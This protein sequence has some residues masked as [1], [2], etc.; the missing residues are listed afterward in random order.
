M[1]KQIWDTFGTLASLPLTPA[2]FLHNCFEVPRSHAAS[3]VIKFD[4]SEQNFLNARYVKD[5]EI[6]CPW[7]DQYSNGFVPIMK[8]D[9]KRCK[10]GLLHGKGYETV[11]SWKHTIQMCS[12]RQN[13]K[14]K[15]KAFDYWRMRTQELFNVASFDSLVPTADSAG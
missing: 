10:I 14:L 5:T 2:Y 1:R 15:H 12:Q 13:K 9:C 11:T 7:Y 8:Q 3:F 4:Q 6:R